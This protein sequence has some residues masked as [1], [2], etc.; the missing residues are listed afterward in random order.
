MLV[1]ELLFV[2]HFGFV[3]TLVLPCGDEHEVFIVTL[4]LAVLGLVLNSEVAA[5]AFLALC[6]VGHDEACQLEV[7]GQAI[8][9]F[10]LGVHL[11]DLAGDED[12]LVEVGL[13]LGNLRGGGGEALL[14]A[15]HAAVLPHDFSQGLV[16]VINTMG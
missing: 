10:Q 11:G 15:G 12:V 14:A 3:V 6:G 13:E 2:H 5:A 9:F 16:V 4:R 7:V 1:V 8:G